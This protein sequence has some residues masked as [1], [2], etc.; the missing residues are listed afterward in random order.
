R[1]LGMNG[2]LVLHVLLLFTV[3][4]CG[5]QF[6]MAQ[7][8]R[9]GPAAAF[10]LAFIGAAV[11]PVYAVFLMPDLFNFALV[12][13]AYFFWLYKEVTVPRSLA[14]RGVWS[15]AI[16]ATLLGIAT[17]SKPTHAPLIVP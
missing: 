2:F 14:L 1:Y 5:Y 3:C 16:A 4:V 6:L 7:S 10:T 13:I 8:S 9:S 11:V 15:D 17:Y 12:F